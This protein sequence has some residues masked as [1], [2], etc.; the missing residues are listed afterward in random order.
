MFIRPK[1]LQFD[2]Q[3]EAQIISWLFYD[4][5]I[6]LIWKWSLFNLLIIRVNVYL[7]GQMQIYVNGCAFLLINAFSS[8]ATYKYLP[9]APL[10]SLH[11]HTIIIYFRTFLGMLKHYV[12]KYP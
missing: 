8:Y 9:K 12:G 5:N 3:D 10:K 11:I 7:Q 1:H 2:K 6:W 4:A